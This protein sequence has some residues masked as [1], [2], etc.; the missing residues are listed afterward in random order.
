MHLNLLQHSNN[1]I[2]IH[3]LN[4]KW[5]QRLFVW[6]LVTVKTWNNEMLSSNWGHRRRRRMTGIK[7][8]SR[9]SLT[10]KTRNEPPSVLLWLQQTGKIQSYKWARQTVCVC[11]FV[12]VYSKETVHVDEHEHHKQKHKI[13]ATATSKIRHNYTYMFINTLWPLSTEI[14]ISVWSTSA[15]GLS[16]GWRNIRMMSWRFFFRLSKS[17]ELSGI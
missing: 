5:R 1:N 8:A 16:L 12:Y 14:E 6:R 11:K 9:H 13:T 7:A 15:L 4:V 2:R 3:R 17:I 10:A